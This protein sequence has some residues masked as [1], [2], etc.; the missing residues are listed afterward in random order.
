MKGNKS[1]I[2][3]SVN[4]VRRIEAKYLEMSCRLET[5]P[6]ATFSALPMLRCKHDP[7]SCCPT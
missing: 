2:S 7:N 1:S 6:D 4:P 5:R 3:K